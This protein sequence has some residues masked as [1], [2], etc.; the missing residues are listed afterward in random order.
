MMI[1]IIDRLIAV[2]NAAVRLHIE[3]VPAPESYRIVHQISQRAIW[4]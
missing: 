3:Y 1:F 4:Y 2:G